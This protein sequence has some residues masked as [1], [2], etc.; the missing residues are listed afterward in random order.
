MKV[1]PIGPT[2]PLPNHRPPHPDR[3]ALVF[4][5]ALG[6]PLTSCGEVPPPGGHGAPSAISQ[7]SC[8]ACHG[9]SYLSTT[10]PNHVEADLPRTCESCHS[11]SAWTPATGGDHDRYWPLTGRHR[12][13][14][15]VSCHADNVYAGTPRECVGCHLPEFVATA[16][17]DHETG[18]FPTSCESCHSTLA[19]R[20][21]TFTDHNRYW[22]LEGR[23]AT[24][25]CTSCHENGVY[26]G[27]PRECVGCHREEYD[28]TTEPNHLAASFPTSCE[29]CH[30]VSAWKPAL[31][32]HQAIWP[33]RG[34]H[35]VA[36]C[37]SCHDNG[38]Y[39]GT[40]RDCVGCHLVDYDTSDNPSHQALSLSKTCQSCHDETAWATDRYPGHDSQFVTSTGDHSRYDCRDCHT[41]PTSDWDLFSCTGC[42][43][44]EHTLA[45]MNAKHDEEPGY[46]STLDT[47]GVERGCLH[48]H[49]DG[50]D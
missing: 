48:C 49:P 21:A 29:T 4:A 27:T 9:G 45:R 1:T 8:W 20:P 40:P 34:Q 39:E 7:E 35:L 30:G 26:A 23:H 33:L 24:T 32:D 18:G 28:R 10:A 37:V 44:G 3:L 12:E 25:A 42:H 15:C 13:V 50:R 41:D 2:R 14:S 16:D 38:V 36:S 17:P 46:Q 6:P 5:L 47:Y 19:W 43:E 22:P 31:F 11:T